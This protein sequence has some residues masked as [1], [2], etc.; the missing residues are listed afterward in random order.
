[1]TFEHGHVDTLVVALLALVWLIAVMIALMVFKMVLVLCNK[2]ARLTCEQFLRRNMC[3]NML[4]LVR[5]IA[6]FVVAMLA[7][8]QFS[9]RH[10]CLV[11]CCL[12]L[13]WLSW[14]YDKRTNE[15]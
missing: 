5:S 10:G 15:Q 4:P 11:E 3:L 12:G 9:F 13:V 7:L 6:S 8:V 2:G 1:M 14:K